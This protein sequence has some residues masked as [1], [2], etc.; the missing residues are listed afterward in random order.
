MLPGVGGKIAESLPKWRIWHTGPVPELSRKWIEGRLRTMLNRDRSRL[1]AEDLFEFYFGALTAGYTGN[2]H[3][4][5]HRFT[6][7]RTLAALSLLRLLPA[8]GKPVLDLACGFGPFA[9]YLTKRRNTTPVIGADFNFYLV[10]GQKHLIAPA[11]VFV[12]AD[13]NCRLPFADDAFSSVFC[14]DAFIYFNSKPQALAEFNRCAPRAPIIL[15]RIGN[16]LVSPFDGDDARAPDEYAQLLAAGAPRGFSEHALVRH[17]LARRNP[18][19]TQ[20]TDP[21]DLNWDKW[22]TFV[23]NGG[24]LKDVVVDPAEEWP[25]EVG[26]LAFNPI[27]HR[28]VL[29]SGRC[30]LS[31]QFPNTWFAYQNGDMHGYHGD[32]VEC[33][34]ALPLNHADAE[35]RN[36]IERFVL[37]GLPERY[38][39]TQLRP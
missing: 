17:Y 23:A 37:I 27:F 39:K 30:K 21:A 26:E 22:L 16:R 8:S 15:T 35:V 25:H 9:H 2:L 28:E 10:W 38:L 18:L 3:Y 11:G 6:L 13:A 19:H 1:C 7:P 31:F 32:R 12:C 34:P 36:L 24:T 14:S 4:Y 5:R 33:S 20:P 29:P